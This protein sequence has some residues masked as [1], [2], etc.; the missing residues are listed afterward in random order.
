MHPWTGWG[1]NQVAPALN[2]VADKYAISEPY[3]Y[4]HNVVLDL[5]LWIGVPLAVLHVCSMLI[6][7]MRRIRATNSLLPWYGLAVA[8]P[9]ILHS[10]LEYPHAYAYFLAPVMFLLGAVE[11]AIPLGSNFRIDAKPVAVIFL[12]TIVILA[13]S[14]I[15]YLKIEEDFRLARYQALRI[16]SPS[17]E[18]QRPRVFFFNQLDSISNAARITPT[19]NMSFNEMQIIRQAAQRYPWSAT[20]YRYALALALNGD[21]I[22]GARQLQVLRRMWGEKMY[23][24]LKTQIAELA[25]TKYPELHRLNLP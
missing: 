18:Y 19:P 20:Q 6:W 10:M 12:T 5:V 23:G 13:W 4:S 2:T 11:A 22:E 1:I 21:P 15:E 24:R 8:L 14:A 3:T 17:H 9:L 7:L 16:G 25:T